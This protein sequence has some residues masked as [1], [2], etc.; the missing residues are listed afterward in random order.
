MAQSSEFI[1]FKELRSKELEKIYLILSQLQKKYPVLKQIITKETAL[2]VIINILENSSEIKEAS[3][4]PTESYNKLKLQSLCIQWMNEATK[5][6]MLLD[7]RNQLDP[8][9]DKKKYDSL[10]ESYELKT[11]HLKVFLNEMSIITLLSFK[12]L[13]I[14]S[15]KRAKP[16]FLIM[17]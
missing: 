17:K 7:E 14:K 12:T 1:K 15:K 3:T 2:D 9:L 6:E 11:D 5:L 4:E 8:N 13:R 16:Q 10:T